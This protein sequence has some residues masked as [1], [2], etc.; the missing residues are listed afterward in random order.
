MK[1]NIPENAKKIIKTLEV[2][3]FEAY[4]VG[5][6]VRDAILA[7]KAD[8]YDITTN[9]TPQEV[10]KLFPRTID[11]GIKHGTVSVLMKEKTAEKNSIKNSPKNSAKNKSEVIWK[12]IEVTTYRIDG[13][14][15]D[16][17]HPEEVTFVK[18]L[19]EDL[20]R[21][22]FTINAMAYNE[23]TGLVDLYGGQDDLNNKI[24]RSVGDP[25]LRFDEDALRMLR[26][27]RFAAKLNFNID[28]ATHHAIKKLSN[29]LVNVSKERIQVELIKI[30]MSENPEYLELAYETG[31]AKYI[32]TDFEKINT[33]IFL[34]AVKRY[35]GNANVQAK[36]SSRIKAS[37]QSASHLTRPEIAYAIL[38]YDFDDDHIDRS[39]KILKDLKLDNKTVDF[40]TKIL[41][42]KK[43]Y[44]D[45][46]VVKAKEI[47]ETYK[48]YEIKRLIS[49]YGYDVFNDF[50]DIYYAEEK[51]YIKD[52][53][54]LVNA[55][56]KK[57][58]PMTLDDLKIRGE[59]LIKIGFKGKEIGIALNNLLDI[60]L[61]DE[62]NN[63]SEKLKSIS[64]MVYN[65]VYGL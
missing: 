52:I 24:I 46:I 38:L 64:K 40:V 49:K 50:L 30:L 2:N 42:I 54:E 19:K 45:Q 48:I 5:G 23:K 65:K 39:I 13:E 56:K 15:L 59:D 53:K 21:R 36:T 25:M 27:V 28:I 11:T 43:Y 47:S 9:A 10:K 29:T 57:N 14:Y 62:A 44:K 3:G 8:D 22:D 55:L 33:E 31:L 26:A 32:A 41:E 12:P 37:Q 35:I 58:I 6:F 7:K 63:T 17:R 4:V 16:S 20:A 18:D 51:R 61:R 1:I 34:D 60:V